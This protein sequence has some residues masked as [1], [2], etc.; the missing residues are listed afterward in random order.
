MSTNTI[1]NESGAT[2]G[3]RGRAAESKTRGGEAAG[4]VA[5][6]CAA[7]EDCIPKLTVPNMMNPAWPERIDG[8]MRE[9]RSEVAAKRTFPKAKSG[10]VL[11]D[12]RKP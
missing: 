10:R 5:T 7:E 1:E 12:R 8:A 2:P 9:E 11:G 3:A 6:I 4:K